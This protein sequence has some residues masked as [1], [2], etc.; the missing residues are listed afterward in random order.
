MEHIESQP[1]QIMPI[2]KKTGISIGLVI[3]LVGAAI[4][5]AVKVT[6]VSSKVDAQEVGLMKIEN[7]LA[8]NYV[9]R[10]EIELMLANIQNSL[11]ALETTQTEIKTL[12]KKQ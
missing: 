6:A 4:T 3:V 5:M 11:K 9:P 1:Q 10:K 12:I 8:D 2:D 7:N